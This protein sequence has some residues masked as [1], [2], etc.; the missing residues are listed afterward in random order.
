[1]KYHLNELVPV[2]D[3][4]VQFCVQKSDGTKYYVVGTYSELVC[5]CPQAR[6]RNPRCKHVA[7]IEEVLELKAFVGNSQYVYDTESE[8]MEP[9]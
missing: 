3:M 7:M 4:P 2:G 5:D 9:A 8:R 1:M 6:Y